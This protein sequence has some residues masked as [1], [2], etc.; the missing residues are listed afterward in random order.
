MGRG[1]VPQGR[2]ATQQRASALRYPPSL[3]GAAMC[4]P[5]LCWASV[6]PACTAAGGPPSGPVLGPWGPGAGP[7]AEAAKKGGR[8]GVQIE[9][10]SGAHSAPTSDSCT[11]LYWVA[12]CPHMGLP[13]PATP[14]Y[15]TS[16]HGVAAPCHSGVPHVRTWGHCT[17]PLRG[18]TDGAS[19]CLILVV[20]HLDTPSAPARWEASHAALHQLLSLPFSWL[21]HVCV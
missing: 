4:A 6:L 7:S 14:G 18:T 12:T 3:S 19:P 15:H 11:L 21:W 17:L 10:G 9:T 1:P 2:A 13:H 8:L 5:A 16:T 20:L